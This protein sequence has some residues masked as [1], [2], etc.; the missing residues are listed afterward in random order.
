LPP[1]QLQE[2]FVH[3]ARRALP[4]TRVLALYDAIQG[5]EQRRDVREVIALT[6]APE[7]HSARPALAGAA[8]P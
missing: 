3:C 1:A 4:E 6:A 7:P 8:R 2:K 5:L